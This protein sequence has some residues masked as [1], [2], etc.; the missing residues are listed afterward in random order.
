MLSTERGAVLPHASMPGLGARRLEPRSLY[1]AGSAAALLLL[2]CLQFPF[3]FVAIDYNR[4]RAEL[5]R[6]E[7]RAP[8]LGADIRKYRTYFQDYPESARAE[9]AARS[10]SDN[11]FQQYH[12]R[13]LYSWI[14]VVVNE[15]MTPFAPTYATRIGVFSALFASLSGTLLALL[16]VSIGWRPLQAVVGSLFG[17]FSFSWLS[18][19]SI[20]ESY[21]VTVAAALVTLLSGHRFIARQSGLRGLALQHGV[22]VGV[23]AWLYP[24]LCGAALL[25]MTG[26]R[27][28]RQY[29]VLGAIAVA[30]AVGTAMLP[31]LVSDLGGVRKQAAYGENYVILGNLFSLGAWRDALAILLVFGIVAPVRDF[32][33]SAGR[34]EWHFIVGSIP[35]L[36]GVCGIGALYAA[37]ARR[38]SLHSVIPRLRG[39]LI[40]G[41]LFLVFAVLYNAR[42][43]LLHAAIAAT[44]TL[45]A[46]AV[47]IEMSDPPILNRLSNRQRVAL[48]GAAALLLLG[49]NVP[50]VFGWP[51][52]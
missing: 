18:M 19:F 20:P 24:P 27:R 45:Y 37:L 25:A 17:I 8:V 50:S 29:L 15:L 36:I 7:L 52:G 46:I 43:M 48:A 32:V 30:V 14:F 10:Q 16:L 35:T 28:A 38:F 22:I 3:W 12:K 21:C 51:S 5:A 1:R 33:F 34:P 39:L 9:N 47:M 44:I 41:G 23:A 31:Q 42:E 11:V 13:P 49:I 6:N 40:W 2:F 4:M 26:D